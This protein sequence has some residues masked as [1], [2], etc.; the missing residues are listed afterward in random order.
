ML[1]EQFLKNLFY[2]K[3]LKGIANLFDVQFVLKKTI[4]NSELLKISILL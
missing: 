2:L 3:N 4:S 1:K